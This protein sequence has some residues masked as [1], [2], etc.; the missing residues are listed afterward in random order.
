MVR[1]AVRVL[2]EL[3]IPQK[4]QGE[5]MDACFHF[6]EEPETPVAIK[7]FSLTTL[8]NLSTLY[9]EIKPELALIIEERGPHETAAFRSRARKILA[10]FEVQKSGKG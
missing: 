1:N 6:L 3:T 5:V 4:F 9:P 10:A 8:F 2:Q 7:A